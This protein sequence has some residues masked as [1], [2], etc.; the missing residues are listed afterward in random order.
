MS[1]LERLLPPLGSLIAFEAAYR[2]GNFTRAAEELFMSQASVSRR[3]RNLETDLGVRLFDRHRY[4]V[5]PTVDAE[6]LAASVRLSLNEL[7]STSDLIRRSA[8]ETNSLTILCS[9]ALTPVIVA[10]I[11]GEFQR[12]H[13]DLTIRIVSAC[14]AIETTREEF[15]I[16]IQYGASTSDNFTVEF[17]ADEAVFPVC[18]PEVAS[19]LPVPV[20]EADL[21]ALRLLDV[22]YDDPSWATWR[23][24]LTS[25]GDMAPNPGQV[26]AFTS[27]EACLDVAERGEGIALGWE[28]SVRPRLDAGTLVRVSGITL[29]NA[30]LINAYV[31]VRN[32]PN[33]Y[34]DEFLTLLRRGL[35]AG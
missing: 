29:A 33:P 11:L 10:P 27:Y 30:G 2:H 20:D 4:D 17:V 6:T 31:P 18:S 19:H 16:A 15:D 12:T 35:T 3:I 9:L 26:I 24:V 34:T 21:A 14:E 25:P 8:T 23:N 7:A 1:D 13:A 22:D 5:T 28:R 32:A